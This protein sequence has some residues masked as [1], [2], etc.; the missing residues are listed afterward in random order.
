MRQDKTVEG[1]RDMK[2][3][4]QS[5]IE[6][7]T[8]KETRT[9][10]VGYKR[11]RQKIMTVERQIGRQSTSQTVRQRQTVKI[12]IR[13]GKKERREVGPKENELTEEIQRVVWLSRAD[14][15]LTSSW[16]EKVNGHIRMKNCTKNDT[17]I[18]YECNIPTCH[19]HAHEPTVNVGACAC[20]WRWSMNLWRLLGVESVNVWLCLW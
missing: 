5:K 10:E 14:L 11:W 20:R 17:L 1:G 9:G 13:R 2:T 4:M 7:Q 3:G 15:Y 18:E 19:L 6:W 12:S 16:S 8:Y